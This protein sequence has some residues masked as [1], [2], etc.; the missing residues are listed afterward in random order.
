MIMRVEGALFL[1]HSTRQDSA[2]CAGKAMLACH[3]ERRCDR[4]DF[5]SQPCIEDCQQCQGAHNARI[6]ALPRE[7]KTRGDRNISVITISNLY[8]SN[9]FLKSCPPSGSPNLR[10]FLKDHLP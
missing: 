3:A 6:P 4:N 10:M 5:S 1:L 2:E 9:V 8:I 7:K